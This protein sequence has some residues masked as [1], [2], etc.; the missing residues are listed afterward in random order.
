[1][2]PSPAASR[3]IRVLKVVLSLTVVGLLFGVF[4]PQVAD[5]G[6]VWRV[7]DQMTWLEVLTLCAAAAW[8]LITYWILM[9]TALPGL[10][11]AQ[12]MVAIETSTAIANT[13]PGGP[14]FGMGISYRMFSSWGFTPRAVTLAVTVSGL[15]DLFAKLAMPAAA[16]VFLVATGD[17]APG[18]VPIA[19]IGGAVL[20]GLTG[21]FWM[22]LHS[23]TGARRAGEILQRAAAPILRWRGKE[24]GAGWSEA[25]AKFRREVVV[26]LAT[27]RWWLIAASFLS[28]VSLFLVL[29]LAL[30]HVGIAD[31]QVEWDEALGAFAFV[32]FLSA[33][34]ITPGGLG[35]VELGLSAALAYAGGPRAE[36]VA[37]VLVFR[38]L[39]FL[40]Q[41]PFGAITYSYWQH[42]SRW[43]SAR[44]TPDTS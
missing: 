38:A 11:F 21:V 5:F 28:H 22:T 40:I 34:P 9:M 26:L 33:V 18:L 14:A 32:R 13:M 2:Q 25:F 1:M 35:V 12:S 36:V 15:A 3:R 31:H 42:S 37:A 23:E 10:S 7:L 27:R 16:V 19:A 43:R 17:T 8:N 6:D 39:T 29:L 30:R 24:E 44:P 4:L 41:I 20:I